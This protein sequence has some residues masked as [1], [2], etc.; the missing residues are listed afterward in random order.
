MTNEEFDQIVYDTMFSNAATIRSNMMT[1]L[2][3]SAYVPGYYDFNWR[4]EQRVI[5][6]LERMW[7]STEIDRFPGDYPGVE[8]YGLRINH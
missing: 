5:D 8:V 6:S 4:H 1:A 3:W 2:Q 7:V